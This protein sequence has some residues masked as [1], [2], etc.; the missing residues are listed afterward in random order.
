MNEPFSPA[1]SDATRPHRRW[2]D[3]F[4]EAFR[5]V[6]LGARGQ[7]SFAVHL[8]FAVAAVSAAAVLCCGWVEWCM[9]AGCIGAVF[10]AELFNTA[11]EILFRGLP[12]EARDRVYGCLDVAAG[13]VLT[14]SLTA[15]VVG[16]V[17]F[18]RRLL[19]CSGVLAES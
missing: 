9:V 18:G 16:G 19:I 10:T 5:G 3:K 8:F 13:A 11:V 4:A 6:W 15:V 17:V 1:A 14:A 12:R 7:S 2:R